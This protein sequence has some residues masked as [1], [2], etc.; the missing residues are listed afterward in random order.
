MG[1]T[2]S[3]ENH[4]N[5]INGVNGDRIAESSSNEDDD[6]KK[7][8]TATTTQDHS[9]PHRPSGGMPLVNYVCRKKKNSYDK[10]V[11][12]WYNTQFLQSTGTLNQ[13]EVCGDKF[14]LYRTCILKGIKKEIWDKQNLPPPAEGSP[15]DE[16]A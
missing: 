16:I 10:C 6:I 11:S 15:L 12:H 5:R 4:S 2:Q 3:N 13:E 14:E 7:P 8:N 1:S 9:D